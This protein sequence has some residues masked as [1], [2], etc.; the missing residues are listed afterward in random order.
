MFK[1]QQFILDYCDKIVINIKLRYYF[2]ASQLEFKITDTNRF[3]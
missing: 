3:L 2:K 1:N